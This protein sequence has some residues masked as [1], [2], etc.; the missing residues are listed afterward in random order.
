AYA[1]QRQQTALAHVRF[2]KRTVWSLAEARTALERLL[3]QATDWSRLDEYLLSYLVEPSMIPTLF[4]SSFASS[5]ELVREGV[6]ELHQQEAF[7]PIYMR[8]R[9]VVREVPPGGQS[10]PGAAER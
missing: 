9:L 7:A 4:A 2:K 6:A 8:K 3:G 1:A 10:G 5:L